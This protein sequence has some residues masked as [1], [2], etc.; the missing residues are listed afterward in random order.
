MAQTQQHSSSNGKGAY[1][2]KPIDFDKNIEPDA[3]VGQ[4]TATLDDVRISKT[5]KD[6][7]P[8]LILEWQLTEAVDG[9]DDQ[10]KSVGATVTDFLT[11]F[12]SGDRR[13]R[14]GKIKYAQLCELLSVDPDTIPARIESKADFLDFIK[15][16]KGQSATVWVSQRE[17]KSSGEVRTN[18]NYTAPRSAMAAM[19]EGEEEQEER[20]NTRKPSGKAGAKGK[21]ARR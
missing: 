9:G 10:E 12:P 19:P 13:G 6:E 18:V 8:M 5:S 7:Y 11:F 2:F 17:D 21:S 16:V 4:Y 15:E 1:D 3:A 20:H 14:M